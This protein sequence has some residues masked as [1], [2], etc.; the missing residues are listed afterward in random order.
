MLLLV[1]L[2]NFTC[3]F[4]ALL[5]AESTTYALFDDQNSFAQQRQSQ[6][7]RQRSG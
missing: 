1:E 4:V 7:T 2:L 3:F 6:N 5:I